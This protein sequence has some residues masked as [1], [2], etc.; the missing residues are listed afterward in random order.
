[1]TDSANVKAAKYAVEKQLKDPLSAQYRN[2]R[3]YYPNVV[4]GEVNAKNGHGGYAGFESFMFE[5]ARGYA[6]LNPSEGR[7]GLC[8]DARKNTKEFGDKLDELSK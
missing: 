5:K 3:E 2:I 8:S 7:I 6:E 4:C 1:M